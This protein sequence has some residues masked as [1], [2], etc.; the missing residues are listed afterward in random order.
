[1]EDVRQ[2]IL[3]TL[4]K[5]ASLQRFEP[6]RLPGSVCYSGP[7]LLEEFKFIKDVLTLAT[8]YPWLS[9]LHQHCLS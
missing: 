4:K 8:A 1:M 7:Q 2:Y 3:G 9:N 6:Q 5:Y